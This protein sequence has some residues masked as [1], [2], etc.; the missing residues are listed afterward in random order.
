MAKPR[1]QREKVAWSVL[2]LPAEELEEEYQRVRVR[3]GDGEQ[4]HVREVVEEVDARDAQ[5]VAREPLQGLRQKVESK[6]RIAGTKR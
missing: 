2:H 3:V 1:P 4:V 5:A 6:Y